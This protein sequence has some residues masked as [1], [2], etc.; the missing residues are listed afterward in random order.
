[1]KEALENIQNGNFAKEFIKECD[2]GHKVLKAT[3]ESMKQ[4]P[5]E[6]T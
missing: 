4:H 1:M 2:N 6:K 5:I 3:R